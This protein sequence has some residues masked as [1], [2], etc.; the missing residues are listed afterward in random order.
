M[1]QKA[2][3]S[4]LVA[5]TFVDEALECGRRAGIDQDELLARLGIQLSQLEGLNAAQF[6]RVWLELS[7]LMEDEFFGLGAR[8]MRPGSA[9]LLGHAISGAP[10]V[11]VGLRRAL[12][13]LRVVLDEP[14]G[15]MSNN[16]S[17]CVVTLQESNGPISAFAYRTF[18]LILHGFTCWM[19]R[20]QIPLISVYFPC[21]APKHKSD[22]EDFFGVP[23]QFGAPSARLTFASK[24]LARPVKRSES[25]LK[26]F[27][28]TTPESLLRGYRD[29]GSLKQ[30]LFDTCLSGP[31][32]HWPDATQAAR[33]LSMSR[34]TLHRRLADTGQSFG[35]LRQ[36]RLKDIATALL[37]HTDQS[38]TDVAAALGYAEAS[39]FYRAFH[40][41]FGTTP[42]AYRRSQ[43]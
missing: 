25:D 22:Y 12:R 43:R 27:L 21:D 30:R 10:D 2:T 35:D 39:T 28:R 38:I 9:T 4:P 33:Q 14:Y 7:F 40:R 34:S 13:F 23:V 15:L 26:A 5:Q 29:T 3:S 1:T 37:S 31:P 19:A 20:E 11:S 32:E 16:G 17:R 18:F 24:Y 42:G 8:P 36:E 6:A 41:W